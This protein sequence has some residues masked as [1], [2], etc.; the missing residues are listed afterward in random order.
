MFDNLPNI[1]TGDMQV[2]TKLNNQQSNV[3]QQSYIQDQQPMNE[4]QYQ[5]PDEPIIFG[6]EEMNTEQFID[7][8]YQ[9][10]EPV[11][12]ENH[13]TYERPEPKAKYHIID[14]FWLDN[15]KNPGQ[16]I[17]NYSYQDLINA[18]WTHEQ[19]Q[20]DSKWS[21]TLPESYHP[22]EAQYVT[23]SYNIDFGNLRINFYKSLELIIAG[24]IYPS[25][26]FQLL[27]SNEDCEI[28]ATEQL[29]TYT[30]EDWQKERPMCVLNRTNNEI[31]LTIKDTKSNNDTFFVFKDWQRKAF[32]K[33][34]RYTYNEG[35]QL[36][37]MNTLQR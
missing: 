6:Q 22:N 7:Q 8:N 21:K 10:P 19:I 11:H 18:G 3:Y 36:R 14:L 13:D 1:P 9:S 29:L 20:A 32:E 34:L 37:G 35:L 17:D 12:Q 2:G 30:G 26:C 27:E 23:I 33:A 4:F 5:V 25:A 31:K 16:R 28:I 24:T 15:K